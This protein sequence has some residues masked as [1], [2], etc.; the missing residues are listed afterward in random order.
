M[1]RSINIISGFFKTLESLNFGGLL[2]YTVLDSEIF[3]LSWSFLEQ[4]LIWDLSIHLKSVIAADIIGPLIHLLQNVEFDIKKEAAWAISNAT[5]GGPHEQ[6][7]QLDVERM[8]V[9]SWN[10]EPEAG[11]VAALIFCVT[12]ESWL[13]RLTVCL[14]PE[15]VAL[16]MRQLEQ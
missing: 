5:S 14:V 6:I 7:K 3:F 11:Q 8:K 12:H 9:K 10:N 13:T 15:V 2:G 1:I 4:L 16:N